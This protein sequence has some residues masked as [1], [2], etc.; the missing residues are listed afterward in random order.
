[1]TD[2]MMAFHKIAAV[3]KNLPRL[4]ILGL[5]F[6]KDRPKSHHDLAKKQKRKSYQAA[7]GGRSGVL[8]S[9]SVNH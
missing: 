5:A 7:R 9:R 1:M 6:P 3:A 2:W 8:H 4:E